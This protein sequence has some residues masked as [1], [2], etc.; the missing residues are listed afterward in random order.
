MDKHTCRNCDNHFSGAYCNKC[1]QKLA[2]RIT[3]GHLAHDILHSFTHADKGFFHLMLGLFKAPGKVAREYIIEEKRKRYFTPFQYLLIIGTIATFIVVNSH[4]MENA[5]KIMT[6]ADP[7]DTKQA[8]AMQQVSYLQSKY[9]NIMILLQLPF[10]AL[11]TFWLYRKYKL[12]YAEHLTLHTFIT[13]QTT[14]ISM[15]LMLFIFITGRDVNVIRFFM[16]SIWLIST[17]Y[18]IGVYIQF[19]QQRTVGGFFRGLLSYI[20]GMVLFF[21][22]TV[23][24]TI[25]VVFIYMMIKKALH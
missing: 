21:V 15:L 22:S 12:N 18:H 2:H 16:T 24:V 3:M 19:F 7:A 8:A 20:L 9:Y 10:M 5:M 13:A 17:A 6:M 23:I 1:G 25:V 14:L 11:A 4:F